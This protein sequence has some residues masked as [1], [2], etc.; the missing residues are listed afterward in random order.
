MKQF[1]LLILILASSMLL[2]SGVAK[3]QDT[4]PPEQ[5]TICIE[6]SITPTLQVFILQAVVDV[7]VLATVVPSPFKKHQACYKASTVTPVALHSTATAYNSR[8]FDPK[9]FKPVLCYQN[10]KSAYSRDINAPPNG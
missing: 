7:N 9:V 6:K 10:G 4:E 8:I 1:H 3:A 5:K 2:I